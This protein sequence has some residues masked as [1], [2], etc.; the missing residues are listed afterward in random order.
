M[1]PGAWRPSPAIMQTVATLTLNPTIDTSYAV[2]RLEPTI[3]LRSGPGRFEPGGG[4]IN[5]S[6]VLARMGMTAR[7]YYCAGGPAGAAL[8][9]LLDQ[10]L[11]VVHRLPVAA[12]T[13]V[14]VAVLES[15]TGRQYR[16]V[17]QGE[18][19]SETEWRDC[20]AAILADPAEMIVASG[21]LP[22]GV[23][24]DFYAQLAHRLAEQGRRLVLDT[25][26]EALAAALDAGGLYL[27]KPSRA[28]LEQA[29]GRQFGNEAEI[30][31]AAAALVAQGKARI[32]A[33]SLGR[34][35]ALVA[36]GDAVLRLPAVPVTAQGSV[37]AGD[38]F[39][40]AMVWSIA[41]NHSLPEAFRA[42]IAAGAAAVLSPGTD[43]CRN[44]DLERLLPQVPQPSV[45]LAKTSVK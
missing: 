40:A 5:V 11:L 38:S 22:P 25:S 30:A 26:G 14:S 28:E 36:A 34:D 21:S 20:L 3:K 13:R 2:D 33:V 31:A 44:A 8:G 42:G 45:I 12:A 19:L 4:G 27:V 39:L 18:P 7:A 10:H 23:P 15:S 16:I 35:G 17:P 43:L 29:L 9:G 6:R 41:A 32:V 37:G 24:A 1:A